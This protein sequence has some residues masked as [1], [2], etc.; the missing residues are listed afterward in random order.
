MKKAAVILVMS[1]FILSAFL[2]IT[3][4][5]VFAQDKNDEDSLWVHLAT[6]V[7][8]KED[9]KLSL[10][11]TWELY[12]R[13]FN[14]KTQKYGSWEEYSDPN[15]TY[16]IVA[17]SDSAFANVLK[18]A[19]TTG[20]SYTMRELVWAMQYFV[21][22]EPVNV[23]NPW[24]TDYADGKIFKRSIQE[25]ETDKGF[26][27]GFIAFSKAGGVLMPAIYGLALFGLLVVLPIT[28]YKLRLAN[29]FPPNKPG[30][31]YSALPTDQ[32]GKTSL[33][34][35]KGNLFIKEV[36]RYWREA[37]KSM[38]LD[39]D[40]WE[41]REKYIK[42][43]SQEQEEVKKTFWLDIGSPNIEKAIE[44]CKNGVP[45]I[46]LKKDPQ[47]YPFTRVF[48][49]ALENHKANQNK[50]WASQEMDRATENTALKELDSLK[51]WSLNA[52]W[53][54]GSIEPMLGLF[55]TVI[56]IRGAFM[57]IENMI[58]EN[59]DAQLTQV[60][61]QLAG[62]IHVALI[63]TITGLAIGVPFMLFYYFYRGKLDWI[64]GKWEEII[65]DILNRA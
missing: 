20:S 27:K 22:V 31:I 37:M 63:T 65:I 46:K 33:K 42:A 30:F 39:P 47:E 13:P 12:R 57:S 41:T 62:G 16:R 1:L 26:L 6:G 59:P 3:Q 34:S 23:V 56:G 36:A 18:S 51:G 49:A 7:E 35:P 8:S 53:A 17:A 10:S 24:K 55:G 25:Q 32:V 29:I 28:W 11:F 61:P 50:W 44:V 60:V 45:G 58:K 48:L 54:I 9:N 5:P 15:L 4:Q 2:M 38:S 52:L 43:D 19:E 40:H 21:R 64:Y 14:A